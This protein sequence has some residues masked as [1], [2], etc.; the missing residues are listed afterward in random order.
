MIIEIEVHLLNSY[1]SVKG[2]EI[3]ETIKD[4]IYTTVYKAKVNNDD[5]IKNIKKEQLK[6]DIK[7][8]DS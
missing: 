8:L 5:D 7:E 2:F 1:N 3:L 4:N 6:D